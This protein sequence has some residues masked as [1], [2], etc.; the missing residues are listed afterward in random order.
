M[1]RKQLSLRDNQANINIQALNSIPLKATSTHQ[2]HEREDEA[3]ASEVGST[4]SQ[5][6]CT[7]RF[8]AKI[9][10]T[11]QEPVR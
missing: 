7:V 8:V 1:M 11:Q 2:L 10:A 6:S 3:K 5:E 4:Q 9:K